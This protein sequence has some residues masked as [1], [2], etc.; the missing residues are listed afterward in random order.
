MAT[1]LIWWWG[2]GQSD[3]RDH[4]GLM[5]RVG[6]GGSDRFNGCGE[7]RLCNGKLKEGD[8][9]V[10][11]RN[12]QDGNWVQHIGIQLICCWRKVCILG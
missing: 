9:P 3:W 7:W 12:R 10:A 4:I 5:W 8:A 6:G 11:A 2:G 1:G